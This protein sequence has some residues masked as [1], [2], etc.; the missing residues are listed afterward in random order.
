[1]ITFVAMFGLLLFRVARNLKT[2]GRLE[3][4]GTRRP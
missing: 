1:V 2:L 3:P 4:P